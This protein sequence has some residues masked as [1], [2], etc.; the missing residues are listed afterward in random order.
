MWHTAFPWRVMDEDV[1]WVLQQ[2]DD[3]TVSKDLLMNLQM[4]T[5]PHTDPAR[6]EE[7][8]NFVYRI[9]Y[10]TVHCYHCRRVWDLS[11]WKVSVNACL[12]AKKGFLHIPSIKPEFILSSRHYLYQISV[13]YENYKVCVLYTYSVSLFLYIYVCVCVC[14]CGGC[15]WVR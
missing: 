5:L 15:L 3:F 6:R 14:V 7:T 12:P 8:G 10:F 1:E 11:F 2:K 13:Q 4:E 9:L